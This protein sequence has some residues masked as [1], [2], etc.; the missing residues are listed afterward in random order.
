MTF[1]MRPDRTL[2][3][4]SSLAPATSNLVRLPV[5]DASG[6]R[7]A[8]LERLRRA[9]TVN[10]LPAGTRLIQTQLA[11]R[12]GV[13]R[14]PVRDAINDLIAEGLAEPLPTGGAMVT[15]LTVADMRAVYAVRAPLELEAVRL[16]AASGGNDYQ[17]LDGVI[18]RHHGL[19]KAGA[20]EQLLDLDRD[21][22]W[23]LY[24]ATGNRFL[25]ASL[26]PV[27]SQVSRIMFAVLNIP[28][29]SEVAWREHEAIADAV[30][31]GNVD[32]AVELARLHL[33]NGANRLIGTFE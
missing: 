5:R 2:A 32:Q 13:S 1:D 33:T 23:A 25:L 12:L 31:A 21:F 7:L 24:R 10:E 19:L 11:E 16:V 3:A 18:E 15:A 27:W 26:T 17:A 9:I 28:S 6:M 20:Q 30:K 4:A 22:H 8:V 14:M 29:Y